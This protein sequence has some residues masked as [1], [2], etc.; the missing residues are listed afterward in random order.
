LLTTTQLDVDW[1]NHPPSG[2]KPTDLTFLPGVGYE[3]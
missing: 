3:W 1:D 2:I